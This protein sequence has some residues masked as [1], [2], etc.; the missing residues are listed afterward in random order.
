MGSHASTYFLLCFDANWFSSTFLSI[1][2]RVGIMNLDSAM[3]H[4]ILHKTT[5]PTGI[6]NRRIPL[7]F[8]QITSVQYNT[9]Q[10]CRVQ[11]SH[12]TKIQYPIKSPPKSL[13]VSCSVLSRWSGTCEW[14]PIPRAPSPS[15]STPRSRLESSRN[16]PSSGCSP[17]NTLTQASSRPLVLCPPRTSKQGCKLPYRTLLEKLTQTLASAAGNQTPVSGF[18]VQRANHCTTTD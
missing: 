8:S 13:I 6:I 15:S 11:Y 18:P 12:L 17:G 14:S 16:C 4:P 7:I 10:C 5:V 1:F 2:F 3:N 9:I